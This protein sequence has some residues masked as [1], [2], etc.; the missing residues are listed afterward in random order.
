[1]IKRLV[2][3]L[4]ENVCL[5]PD[6]T[7]FAL[8]IQAKSDKDFELQVACTRCGAYQANP[9]SALSALVTVNVKSE[10]RT[11]PLVKGRPK[12]VLIQGGASNN[13]EANLNE[14]TINRS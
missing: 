13:N 5:C 2:V 6:G 10:N 8:D 1:M 9:L 11:K 3:E 12:L 4:T 14:D 7:R